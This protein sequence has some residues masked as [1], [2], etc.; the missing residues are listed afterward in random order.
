MTRACCPDCRLRFTSAATA[1]FITCPECGQE[2][3]PAPS[4]QAALGYRLFEFTDALP[5]LPMAGEAVL[6]TGTLWP[7]GPRQS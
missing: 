3:H 5:E 7:D 1:S 6:P 4:A 2:L